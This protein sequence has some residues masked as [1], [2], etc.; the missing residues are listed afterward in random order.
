MRRRAVL[1]GLIVGNVVAP[2][3]VRAQQAAWPVIGF[4]NSQFPAMW[5]GYVAAFRQG[6]AES[7]FVE[8]QNLTIEYRWAEAR[9]NRLPALAAELVRHPVALIVATGGDASGR[10]AA[11]ATKTIPIVFSTGADPVASGLVASLSHPGGNATGVSVLTS[12]LLKKRVELVR[13][14]LPHATTVGLLHN[15]T[16][17]N[18]ARQRDDAEAEARTQQLALVVTGART[19]AELDQAFVD[20]DRQRVGALVIDADPFF[21]SRADQVVALA[22]RFAIPTIYEWRDF[23][24]AGGLMSYGSDIR[25]GYRQVGIYAGRILKGA[26]PEDL[27]VVQSATV[28]LVINLKTA[29]ALGLEIPPALLGRAD[30]VIE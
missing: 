4:L 24:E 29:T 15:S 3:P 2:G 11:A 1:G 13:P 27:P 25:T 14:L 16:N 12:G 19:D 9:Y 22:Q 23:V 6:L 21:L 7:G 17:Q 10:A 5:A 8:G 26:K 20:L 28:G 18:A 30:E